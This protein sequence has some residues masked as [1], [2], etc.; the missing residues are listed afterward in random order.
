MLPS[1][2]ELTSVG[3][4]KERPMRLVGSLESDLFPLGLQLAVY[5]S[6]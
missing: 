5:S 6:R 2:T 4:D 1:E 3:T